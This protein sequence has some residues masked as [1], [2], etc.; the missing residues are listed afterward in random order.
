MQSQST[1]DFI[2]CEREHACMRAYLCGLEC[3]FDPPNSLL[4]RSRV[5]FSSSTAC[6]RRESSVSDA[7]GCIHDTNTCAAYACVRA[8]VSVCARA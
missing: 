4:S 7:Q 2:I 8:C 6:K 3:V 1:F 5:P